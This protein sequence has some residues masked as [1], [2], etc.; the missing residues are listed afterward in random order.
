MGRIIKLD[1]YPRCKRLAIRF[2]KPRQ[3]VDT[4][5]ASPAQPGFKNLLESLHREP[6]GAK[7][8]GGGPDPAVDPTARLEQQAARSLVESGQIASL[9]CWH[10]AAAPTAWGD[11]AS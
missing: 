7:R 3:S 8:V 6:D 5:M 1:Q 4:A 11:V 9:S 2:R 10:F